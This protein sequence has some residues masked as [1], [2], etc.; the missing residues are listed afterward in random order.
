MN[1]SVMDTRMRRSDPMLNTLGSPCSPPQPGRC[2]VFLG[3]AWEVMALIELCQGK[4]NKLRLA[5][6]ELYYGYVNLMVFHF[7]KVRGPDGSFVQKYTLQHDRVSK[8]FPPQDSS[9]S[10][11]RSSTIFSS[12]TNQL[13]TGLGV[14]PMYIVHSH[15]HFSGQTT[16]PVQRA[17]CTCQ[18]RMPSSFTEI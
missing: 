14:L 2:F 12:G 5:G 1:V 13:F 6:T 11:S 4:R 16:T 15:L 8:L 17:L 18:R 7:R 10:I 3:R 9:W